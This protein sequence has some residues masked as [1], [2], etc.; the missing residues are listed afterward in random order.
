MRHVLYTLPILTALLLN[1]GS[2]LAQT[3]D[4]PS[5]TSPEWLGIFASQGIAVVLVVWWIAK[6]YPQWLAQWSKDLQ[7]QREEFHGWRRDISEDI[8]QMRTNLDARPCLLANDSIIAKL[9]LKEV[10]KSGNNGPATG[11]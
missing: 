1:M 9:L 2:A 5:A 4:L 3:G 7:A 11:A 10:D 6:G 8:R